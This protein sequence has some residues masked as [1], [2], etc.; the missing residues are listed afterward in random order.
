MSKVGG[1]KMGFAKAG[2]EFNGQIATKSGP[3]SVGYKSELSGLDAARTQSARNTSKDYTNPKKW[4][5][6]TE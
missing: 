6:G 4:K 1:D 3:K 2:Q 5:F